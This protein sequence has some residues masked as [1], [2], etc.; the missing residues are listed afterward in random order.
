MP[1]P[2]SGASEVAAVSSPPISDLARLTNVPSDNFLAE[3]LLKAV[4]GAF[5][6]GGSTSEGIEVVR[7][8]AADRGASFSGENGSGLSRRDRASPASV[9]SPAGLDARG[10]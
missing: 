6:D 10:R 9:G 1:K 5:G 4:G 2:E 8:F 3:M 7:E